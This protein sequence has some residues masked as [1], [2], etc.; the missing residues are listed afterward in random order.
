M[1]KLK[2]PYCNKDIKP[3]EV[4]PPIVIICPECGKNIK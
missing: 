4:R 2:C 1:K 3:L